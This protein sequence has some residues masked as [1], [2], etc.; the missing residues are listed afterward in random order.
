MTSVVCWLANENP[1]YQTLWIAADSLI[2]GTHPSGN[3]N[4][5][6]DIMSK[7]SSIPI[8][9]DVPSSLKPLEVSN[10]G[11]AFAGS[12]LVAS[13]TKDTFT[14]LL[15]SL[16]PM[17]HEEIL[18]SLQEIANLAFEVFIG[19]LDS[20]LKNTSEIQPSCE[21]LIFGYC[22]STED[23]GCYKISHKVRSPTST[24]EKMPLLRTEDEFLPIIIGDKIDTVENLINQ[25]RE[26]L[27]GIE[28]ERAP[29]YSLIEI[30]NSSE[31]QTIG[32]QLQIAR[33]IPT[34]GVTVFG[35]MNKSLENY[36]YGYNPHTLLSDGRQVLK[37]L[38]NFIISPSTLYFS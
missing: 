23:F 10:V 18:P 13:A 17:S 1:E 26:S 16:Q 19:V 22:H 2:S 12:T 24:M 32:G 37:T 28:R 33:C 14:F 34:T 3:P 31:Q 15:S 36:Y 9:I 27:T 21:I 4:P 35:T 25:K 5:M 29:M 30:I 20:F 7:I 8:K 11:F 38:G 6:L